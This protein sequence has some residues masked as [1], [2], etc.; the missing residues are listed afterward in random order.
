[1]IFDT[2]SVIIHLKIDYSS[3]FSLT[4]IKKFNI[5]NQLK[6]NNTVNSW[7]TGSSPV[8]KSRHFLGLMLSNMAI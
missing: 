7:V 2:F 4:Y 8:G 1:M 5:S 3:E 6:C